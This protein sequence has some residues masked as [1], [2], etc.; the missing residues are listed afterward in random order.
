M[1]GMFLTPNKSPTQVEL[2]FSVVGMIYNIALSKLIKLT[3]KPEK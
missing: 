3:L 2:L 1:T